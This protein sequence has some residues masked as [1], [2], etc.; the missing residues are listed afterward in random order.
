MARSKATA[1]AGQACYGADARHPVRLG[2]SADA[3]AAAHNLED[4]YP[5]I[6]TLHELHAGPPTPTQWKDMLELGGLSIRVI[7][8]IDAESVFKSFSSK[9]LKKP[10]GCALLG[11]ISWIRQMMERGIAHGIQWCD[12]RDMTADGHAKGSID[13]YMLVQV[14]GGTRSFKHDLKR[15]TPYRA[16]QTTS[17]ETA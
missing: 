5:T 1:F 10:A 4:C 2:Y 3:L 14:I 17:R 7:L 16:G 11:H 12:T 8:T 13:I 9:D 6:V 15:H